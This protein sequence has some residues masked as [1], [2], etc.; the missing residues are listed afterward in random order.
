M[1]YT[2][3]IMEK[4]AAPPISK[5]TLARTNR[6]A[7]TVVLPGDKS[8]SHRAALFNAIATGS[9]TVSNLS[10]GADV[11][12]TLR[13][14]QQLGV[15]IEPGNRQGTYEI[16]GLG[17]RGL[18]EPNDVLDAGNSG[19]TLRLLSG[20]LAHHPFFS[21]LTGDASLR[22]RPVYRVVE[23]LRLMGASLTARD[24]D[25]RPP[26]AIR[27]TELYG[28]EYTLP[29]ASAQVKTAIT[30]AALVAD[31]PTTIHQ[32]AL[33]RDHTEL[34]LRAMGAVV[35]EDGL[36]LTIH[37][38]DLKAINVEVPGDIS[39]A[40]FWLVAA[41]CH[42]NAEVRVLN[43]GVNPT[44]TGV[45]E[46]LKAMGA[47]VQLENPRTSGGEP[48]A[49]LVARS[50]QLKATEIAGDLLVN[51]IDEIPILAVAACFAEGA[52]VVRDA[53]ELRVKESD[54]IKSIVQELGRLGASVEERE[55]GLVIHGGQP[56]H[57][58]T[59][60]SHGDHRMAMSMAVA[61]SL[62]KGETTVLDTTAADIS[63]PTFWETLASLSG[64]EARA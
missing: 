63:Y 13:C 29:V 57:G 36:S 5:V 14:L 48:V 37:P 43:V 24:D 10:P 17:T 26:L 44:R 46:V 30:L 38:S 8:I 28:I 12:S 34:M 39:S 64:K 33:S 53:Q 61:G 3:G 9:A 55:D 62:A 49:D 25:R 59:V 4:T 51:A 23:P 40:A 22:S 7:G 60:E 6:L 54:R 56:L 21:V 20:V 11:V 27:G 15:T 16:T 35:E 32:P 1:R 41:V 50:S 19:T 42:P 52:T 2:N 47:D 31:A 18:T 45:L 58:A